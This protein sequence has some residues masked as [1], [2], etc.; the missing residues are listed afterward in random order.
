MRSHRVVET[1]LSCVSADSA[2]FFAEPID[3]EMRLVP[4]EAT[5]YT[6]LFAGRLTLAATGTALRAV[7]LAAG[8]AGPPADGSG[9]TAT[10]D[11]SGGAL[12]ELPWSIK[13]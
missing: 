12:I 1:A 4:Q 6:E 10:P 2:A 8:I 3:Q 13:V 7:R 9:F 11:F 5:S